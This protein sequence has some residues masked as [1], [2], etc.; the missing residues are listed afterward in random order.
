MWR[1]LLKRAPFLFLQRVLHPSH[2]GPRNEDLVG[3]LGV[4]SQNSR[5]PDPD[6]KSCEFA[7]TVL[8][9]PG[10]KINDKD[11]DKLQD[12]SFDT[13][14]RCDDKFLALLKPLRL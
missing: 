6:R 14:G 7:L 10:I 11:P 9:L 3:C 8:E 1:R 12:F 2:H 13:F 5:L 4:C